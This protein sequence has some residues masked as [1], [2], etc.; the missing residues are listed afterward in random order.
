M[1]RIKGGGEVRNCLRWYEV[2]MKMELK[3]KVSV[4]GQVALPAEIRKRL[5]IKTGDCVQFQFLTDGGVRMSL[6][7]KNEPGQIH[8]MLGFARKFRKVRPSTEWFG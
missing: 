1:E 4:R 3:A 7:Q 2:P 6:A 5:D 8:D